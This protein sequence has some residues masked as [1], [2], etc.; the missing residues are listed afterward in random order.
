VIFVTSEYQQLSVKGIADYTAPKIEI[1]CEHDEN[2]FVK[3][4]N[5]LPIFMTVNKV[6]LNSDKL[7]EPHENSNQ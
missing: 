6:T 5:Y 1:I 2:S 4:S 3:L 7:N